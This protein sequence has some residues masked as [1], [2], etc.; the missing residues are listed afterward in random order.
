MVLYL[1]SSA[2]V[3]LYVAEVGTANVRAAVAADPVI[4]TA[5]IT[6]VEIAA[7]LAA[8]ARLGRIASIG[9]V[10]GAFRAHWPAYVVVEIDRALAES[11]ADLAA[12]HALRGYD[13]V[14]LA[15]ALAVAGGNPATVRFAT[16]DAAL[17]SAADAEG[18]DR[19]V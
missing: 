19:G 9:A 7:A 12:R 6:Y 3:K 4:V 13:A 5:R 8:A 18:L 11:A 1:D 15:A 14:Q 17:T 2:A 10:M 16:F